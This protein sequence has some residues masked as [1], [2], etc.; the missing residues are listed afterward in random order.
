MLDGLDIGLGEL[1]LEQVHRAARTAG[2]SPWLMSCTHSLAESARWSNWPGSASTAKTG[3]FAAGELGGGDVDLRLG[4]YGG[5]A[6]GEQLLVD[7]L[8]VV[9]VDDAQGRE[10]LDAQG[11]AELGEQLLSLDVEP[12]FF[13]T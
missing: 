13:S 2:R 4:E 10:R 7:A 1:A 3:P 6:A 5:H 9:A 8:D 11:V 12:G